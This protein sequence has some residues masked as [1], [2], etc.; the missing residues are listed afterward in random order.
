MK[1]RPHDAS[2]LQQLRLDLQLRNLCPGTIENYLRIILKLAQFLNRPLES[3]TV[4]DLRGYA[5]HLRLKRKVSTSYYNLAVAAMRFWFSQSMRRPLVWGQLPS[6]KRETT[7]PEVLSVEETILMLNYPE[8]SLKSRTLLHTAYA[9]GLRVSE[10]CRLRI[11]D[12]DSKRMLIRIQNGKGRKERF[13]MLSPALLELLREYWKAYR[14]TDWL[15][16]P[17]SDRTR[18]LNKR[19]VQL[20]F[21]AIR[22]AVGIQKKASPHTLRHSFATH[23]L[24]HGTDLVVIQSLL[25]HRNISTTTRYLHVSRNRI[26]STPSPLD[27]LTR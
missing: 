24:E 16:F 18:P 15:F 27:L 5:V 9:G 22:K 10:L 23:L 17:R 19:A 25:G 4:E 26:A 7:L 8:Q 6:G 13:V 1:C 14:P 11:A 21:A 3:C 2:L 20:K 12:I